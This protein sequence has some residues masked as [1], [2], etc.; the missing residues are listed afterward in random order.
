M[1]LLISTSNLHDL[2]DLK[3]ILKKT[4]SEVDLYTLK[5]LSISSFTRNNKE[6]SHELVERLAS[7]YAQ[8]ASKW[9]INLTSTLTIPALSTSP[10]FSE[11]INSTLSNQIEA[12]DQKSRS[13]YLEIFISLANPDGKTTK[14]VQTTS[15]GRVCV[16]QRGTQGFAFDFIFIKEGY[17]KTL[18]ELNLETRNKVSPLRKAVDKLS[19][20]F[21]HTLINY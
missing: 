5:D 14:T 10:L 11:Q 2:R 12:L 13:A 21:K 4:L 7:H 15:E 8:Q 9:T 3:E 16:T 18:A 20:A 17:E 6:S 1:D 19:L